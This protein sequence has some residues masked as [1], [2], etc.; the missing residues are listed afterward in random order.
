MG[1]VVVVT[2]L[3]RAWWTDSYHF[4]KKVMSALLLSKVL[5]LSA[6]SSNVCP[7]LLSSIQQLFFSMSSSRQGFWMSSDKPLQ[8]LAKG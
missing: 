8:L 3:D 4:C 5:I 1:A 6:I 2:F 7:V